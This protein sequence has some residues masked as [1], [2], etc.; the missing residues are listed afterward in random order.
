MADTHPQT[1]PEA[2]C[3]PLEQEVLEEYA[4]LLSNLNDVYISLSPP[5]CFHKPFALLPAMP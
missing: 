3:T 2:D 4:T 1:H 5:P